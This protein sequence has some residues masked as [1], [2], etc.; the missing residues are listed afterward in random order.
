MWF[1]FP[2][3]HGLGHSSTARKFALTSLAEARACLRHP[4]LGPRLLECA[5]IVAGTGER[6]AEEAAPEEPLF[7]HVLERH[8]AGRPDAATDVML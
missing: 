6:T 2:Q 4:V 5:A 3:I 7:R 1:V 8:F